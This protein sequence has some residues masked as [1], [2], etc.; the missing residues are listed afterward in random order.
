MKILF[1]GDSI[2]RGTVGVSYVKR[3]ARENPKWQV[4]NAGVNGE[5]LFKIAA[6]LKEKLQAGQTYDS[7]ILQAGYNDI[8][9]PALAQKGFLFRLT[10]NHLIRKNYHPLTAVA[11]F[12]Q[13]YR[14][15]IEYC[16]AHSSAKL[17]ITTMGCINENQQFALN[18][19]RWHY[20]QVIRDLAHKYN[21]G[22]ADPAIMI[23]QVLSQLDTRDYCL[24]HFLNSAWLD[25]WQCTILGRADNL[26]KNR[27][28]HLTIDGVHLNTSGAQLFK[29]EIDKH[30]LTL[31]PPHNQYQVS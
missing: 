8:I 19:Q 30:L 3:I 6:R 29:E 17:I 25:L 28:L 16:Q 26:S 21:C 10:H 4:E 9:L 18:T 27:R 14:N 5:T 12:E 22:L 24:Q 15:L 13:T 2:T 1:I 11:D 31:A 7:I 23:D 20:N